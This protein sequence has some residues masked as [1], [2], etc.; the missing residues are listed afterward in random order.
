[1]LREKRPVHLADLQTQS[2]HELPERKL[3]CLVKVVISDVL[4]NNTF[5]VGLDDINVA[6][7][8]CAALLSTGLF[9]CRIVAHESL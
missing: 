8:L 1:M 6:N 3:I 9:T 5:N 7:G 4:S 2:G